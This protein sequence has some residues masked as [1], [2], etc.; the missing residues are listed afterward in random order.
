MPWVQTSKIGS[1]VPALEDIQDKVI[2]D[3]LLL[4]SFEIGSD[5]EIDPWMTKASEAQLIKIKENQLDKILFFEAILEEEKWV[6]YEFEE[7]QVKID[8]A[9]MILQD[10]ALELIKIVE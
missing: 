10:L 4:N 6:D 5:V 2:S 9:D 7:S 8:L 1:K 3:L